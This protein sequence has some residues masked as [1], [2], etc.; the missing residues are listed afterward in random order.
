MK[1]MLFRD[2]SS[3][4]YGGVFYLRVVMTD[5]TTYIYL[6][7]SKSRVAPLKVQTIPRLELCGARLLCDLLLR[8]STDLHI[9]LHAWT[10]S[11]VLLGW[12]RTSSN[13]LKVFV[14]HRVSH[15]T[16]NLPTQHWRYVHT[17][18]NP[19][20]SRGLPP[21]QLLKNHLWWDGP[22]TLLLVG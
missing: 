14:A 22:L 16:S 15:I 6:V 19:A 5:T 1:Q 9:P 2:A 20:I 13:R 4:T 18:S 3:R 17:A 21:S 7:A 11:A 8:V 12:L 10:D